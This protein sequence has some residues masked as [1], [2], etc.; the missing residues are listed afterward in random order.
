MA[1]VVVS[2][3]TPTGVKVGYFKNPVIELFTADH[4][5]LTGHFY[6]PDGEL[7]DRI[8]FNPQV[9]PYLADLSELTD[10]N[11]RK[12]DQVYVQR[13]RQPVSMTGVGAKG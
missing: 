2:V 7:S 10:Y 3:Y 12:V 11:H 6:D 8:E 13:G 4:Y 1:D 9:L 5:C